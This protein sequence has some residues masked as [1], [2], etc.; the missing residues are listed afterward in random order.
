M[1]HD[2]SAIHELAERLQDAAATVTTSTAGILTAVLQE[3]IEAEL[4]DRIRADPGGGTLWRTKQRN[5]RRPKR[6]P[7]PASDVEIT[8]PKLR[9][10]SFFPNCWSRVAGSTRPCGR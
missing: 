5:G 3:M 10:E 9:T 6:L 8:V 2:Q 1:T 7:T 4:T